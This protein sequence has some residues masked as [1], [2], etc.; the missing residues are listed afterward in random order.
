MIWIP[1]QLVVPRNSS[2][3]YVSLK[4][5]LHQEQFDPYSNTDEFHPLTINALLVVTF[6]IIG[7]VSAVNKKKMCTGQTNYCSHH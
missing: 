5:N 2:D 6:L 7:Q 4:R 3:I 1:E